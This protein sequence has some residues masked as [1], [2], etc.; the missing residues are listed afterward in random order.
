VKEVQRVDG[1]GKPREDHRLEDDLF[2]VVGGETHVERRREVRSELR[3]PAAQRRQHGDRRDLAVARGQ[4]VA[5]VD[6]PVGE[7][8]HVAP[9][10]TEGHDE[11]L[12]G[13]AVDLAHLLQGPS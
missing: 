10:V 2:Q 6:V 1:R 9:E 5:A 8:D 7:L 4:A 12:D 3:F 11:V 13:D